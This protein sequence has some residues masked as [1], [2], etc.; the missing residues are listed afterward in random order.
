MYVAKKRNIGVRFTPTKNKDFTVKI[1]RD[2]D[3]TE[4]KSFTQ[5]KW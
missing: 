2:M 3:K 4:G 5:K 1:I